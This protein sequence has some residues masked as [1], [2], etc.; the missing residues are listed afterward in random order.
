MALWA[1][2]GFQTDAL[3]F[4]ECARRLRMSV[5]LRRMSLA[6]QRAVARRETGLAGVIAPARATG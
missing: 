5:S 2:Y 6:G 4:P 3:C 1:R